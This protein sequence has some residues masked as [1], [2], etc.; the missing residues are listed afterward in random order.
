MPK[1]GLKDMTGDVLDCLQE[2]TGEEFPQFA[3]TNKKLLQNY[4]EY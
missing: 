3:F 2:M 4:L 1:I